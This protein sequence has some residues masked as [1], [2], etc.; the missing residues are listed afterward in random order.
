MFKKVVKKA[1]GGRVR[2]NDEETNLAAAVSI[3]SDQ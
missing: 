2:E 3:N 1:A